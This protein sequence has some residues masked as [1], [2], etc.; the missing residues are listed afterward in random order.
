MPSASSKQHRFM[1]AVAHSPAF[2]KKVG[3][4][5]AV[6]KEFTAEDKKL[7][8]AFAKGGHVAALVKRG[9]PTNQARCMH[10]YGKKG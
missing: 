7:R 9:F 10:A 1:Q 3:V 5:V 4:P 6:G 8:K 2:A